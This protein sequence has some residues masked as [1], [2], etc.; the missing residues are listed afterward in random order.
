MLILP[1]THRNFCTT[2][3]YDLEQKVA[4]CLTEKILVLAKFEVHI[5]LP[6]LEIIAIGVFGGGCESQS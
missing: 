2:Y 3:I 4:K 5:A 1:E 6:V